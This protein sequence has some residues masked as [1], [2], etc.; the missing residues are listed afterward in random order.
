M[1]QVTS[2]SRSAS[3]MKP[4]PGRFGDDV[5]HP[6]GRIDASWCINGTRRA[7]FVV[8]YCP[9]S[10]TDPHGQIGRF[11]PLIGTVPRH[12]RTPVVSNRDSGLGRPLPLVPY[13]PRLYLTGITRLGQPPPDPLASNRVYAYGLRDAVHLR[14]RVEAEALAALPDSTGPRALTARA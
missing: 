9:S 10:R 7:V 12:S 6:I 1:P 3:V 8:D 13:H 4:R 11:D 5:T 14:L 2:E